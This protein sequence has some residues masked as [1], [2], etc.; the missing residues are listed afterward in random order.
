MSR[1]NAAVG[2]G[3]MLTSV[4]SIDGEM[5]RKDIVEDQEGVPLYLDIQLIDTSTCEP[6]PAVV[7]TSNAAFVSKGWTTNL[8]SVYGRLALQLDWR[9]FWGRRVRKW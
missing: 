7:S 9:L 3:M 5:I 1:A 6:V 2:I 8:A 4:R